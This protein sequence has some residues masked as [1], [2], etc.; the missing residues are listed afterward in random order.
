MTPIREDILPEANATSGPSRRTEDIH[1]TGSP[2]NQNHGSSVISPSS[3]TS[4][5]QRQAQAQP[6]TSSFSRPLPSRSGSGDST[7]SFNSRPLPSPASSYS[8][9]QSHGRSA[10]QSALLIYGSSQGSSS[11]SLGPGIN[12]VRSISHDPHQHPVQSVLSPVRSNDPLRTIPAQQNFLHSHTH[13]GSSNSTNSGLALVRSFSPLN[14][15]EDQYTAHHRGLSADDN[16]SFYMPDTPM[17]PQ[18]SSRSGTPTPRN[19]PAAFYAAPIRGAGYYGG[20]G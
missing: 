3:V 9:S 11:T 4:Q 12:H 20:I 2:M 7:T 14:L 13:S 18:H 6:S 10:S 8:Q 16:A 19:D 5:T 15:Y 1:G 17:Q